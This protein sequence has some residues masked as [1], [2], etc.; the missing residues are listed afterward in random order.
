MIAQL[1]HFETDGLC[2]VK[3]EVGKEEGYEENGEKR[4]KKIDSYKKKGYGKDLLEKITV[5]NEF[6]KKRNVHRK[7][8]NEELRMTVLDS[9]IYPLHHP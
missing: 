3:K 9:K 2:Y 6:K 7:V 1:N 8:K 4:L 5:E